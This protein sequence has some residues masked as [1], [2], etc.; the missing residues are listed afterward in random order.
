MTRSDFTKLEFVLEELVVPTEKTIVCEDCE[1]SEPGVYHR[2]PW[3]EIL[4][5]ECFREHRYME[6]LDAGT[7]W[8]SDDFASFEVKPTPVCNSIRKLPWLDFD[9]AD[10]AE[11]TE[12]AWDYGYVVGFYQLSYRPIDDNDWTPGTPIETFFNGFTDGVNDNQ[13]GHPFSP[14]PF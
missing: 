11:S 14:I 8:F 7:A 2:T 1:S 9:L 6:Q 5:D 3:D 12:E 4:C 10:V 13:N